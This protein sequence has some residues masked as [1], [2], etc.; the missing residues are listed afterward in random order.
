VWSRDKCRA[1]HDCHCRSQIEAM[2]PVP[3]STKVWIASGVTDM[4]KGSGIAK[5]E[6]GHAGNRPVRFDTTKTQSVLFGLRDFAGMRR[7]EGFFSCASPSSGI[8]IQGCL[9]PVQICLSGFNMLVSSNVPGLTDTLP[10][11]HSGL[12]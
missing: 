1:G 2:I 3:A 6:S 12:W 9:L 11:R 5:E 7:Q 8:V 10:L 4:R